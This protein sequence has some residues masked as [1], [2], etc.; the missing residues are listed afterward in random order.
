LLGHWRNAAEFAGALVLAWL[1][2]RFVAILVGWFIL[3]PLYF[4]QAL[5]NGAPFRV[6]E[7]VRLLAGSHTGRV[8][9][10]YDVWA[11]RSQVRVELGELA[12]N[13][14]EDV[15]SH[16]EVCREATPSNNAPHLTS[17]E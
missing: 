14:V 1:V 6:G 5:R 2:G 11:E 15:F 12:R 9:R 7:S 4:G 16:V 8:V 17:G 10:I 13:R 3:G